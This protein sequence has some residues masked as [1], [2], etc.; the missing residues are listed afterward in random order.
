MDNI[1]NIIR[2]ILGSI[3]LV[4][5]LP[6]LW[7]ILIP[8]DLHYLFFPQIMGCVLISAIVAM[9]FCGHEDHLQ[10]KRKREN[11]SKSN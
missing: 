2:L 6:L 11:K 10:K 8:I 9:I 1:D 3:F 4:A 5:F 7:H